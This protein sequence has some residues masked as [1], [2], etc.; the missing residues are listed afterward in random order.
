MSERKSTK[1][2]STRIFSFILILSLLLSASAWAAATLEASAPQLSTPTMKRSKVLLSW[3]F[4]CDAKYS[5]YEIERTQDPANGFEL[6]YKAGRRAISKVDRKVS[7]GNAY[8]YRMRAYNKVRRQPTVYSA[9]SNVVFIDNGVQDA[10][11]QQPGSFNFAQSALVVGEDAGKVRVTISR[12]G[13]S[14]GTASVDFRTGQLSAKYDVDYVGIDQRTLAFADGETSK[15]V[16]VGIIADAVTESDETFKVLLSNPSGGAVLGS[17]TE[18]TITIKDSTV[19]PVDQAPSVQISSPANGASYTSAQAVVITASAQDDQGVTKVEFYKDGSLV[20]TDSSAPYSFSWAVVEADNGSHSIVARAFDTAGNLTDSQAVSVSV[21]IAPPTV[22]KPGSFEFAVGAYSIDENAGQLDIVINR[23]GGSDG[24]V[25]V[26]FRTGLITAVNGE[27]YVGISAKP[28]VFANGETWKSVPVSIINDS[29]SEETETFKVLLSNATGGAALGGLTE[30]II[31]VIDDDTATPTEPPVVTG[32]VKAFPGAEGFG[33]DTKAGRGGKI[34][35]VTNLNDSGA[36]SLREAVYY[37]AGP[38]IIVFEVA[39]VITLKS[40]L[41]VREPFM[42]IAGQTAPAP[43]VT[44]AGYGMR[45][46]THDVLLQHLFFRADSTLVDQDCLSIQPSGSDIPYN[47]IVDHCSLAWAYDENL[48]IFPGYGNQTDQNIT[49]SNCLIGEGHYGALIGSNATRVSFLR[50]TVMSTV[51]RQPRLGGGTYAHVVNNLLYDVAGYEFSAVG[52]TWGADQVT[53][54]GNSFISGPSNRSNVPAIG[55]SSIQPGS[56]IYAPNSGA[57]ANLASNS[58][59]SS[60]INTYLVSTPP[61]SLSGISVTPAV[62]LEV[63]MAQSVGARPAQR[64][65]VDDRFLYEIQ[66]R[67]GSVKNREIQP[68][69]RPGSTTRSITPL[70]PANPNGDDN[71]NGYTNIEEVLYQMALEVEGR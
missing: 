53:Y 64:D 13:G 66:T 14:T 38:R 12:T 49:I 43:G 11:P 21:N 9:Y 50:N 1:Y 56:K 60:G 45:I 63:D 23:V 31:T 69:N 29:V 37:T 7:T 47:I 36:G 62:D 39:G 4:D 17:V 28:V 5:G 51:E 68:W 10:V 54:A 58:L 8:Y 65:E 20:A 6:M 25:S 19:A 30:S 22:A 33:A 40:P 46:Y 24:Q 32:P 48:S 26:D 2:Q 67:T 15:S 61:V 70:L 27:D 41:V 57:N 34:V 71:G 42:T 59:T 16:D 35:K 18:A 44:L 52:S 55:T 3:S